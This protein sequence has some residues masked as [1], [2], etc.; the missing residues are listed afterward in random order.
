MPDRGAATHR[1]AA[2][3][4]RMA[5]TAIPLAAVRHRNRLALIKPFHCGNLTC[6]RTVSHCGWFRAAGRAVYCRA[7]CQSVGAPRHFFGICVAHLS[8][9]VGDADKTRFRRIY[10][11]HRGCYVCV[12]QPRTGSKGTKHPGGGLYSTFGAIELDSAGGAA[13]LL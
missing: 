4:Q 7:S 1:R 13:A 8:A 2:T 6:V 9:R 10:R 3:P 5:R 12:A 11:F